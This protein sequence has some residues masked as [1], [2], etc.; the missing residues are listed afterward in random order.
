MQSEKLASMGQLAAGVAHE[1]NNPLGIVL[2]YAHLLLEENGGNGQLRDD[3][4]TI[5]EQAD[6][7]KRI[8]SGLLNFARQNK[9]ICQPTNVIELVQDTIK[10]VN[11][12]DEITVTTILELDEP[13]AEIDREQIAQ[14]LVNLFTN[15]QSAMPSGG[16]LTVAVRGD[17][18]NVHLSV[19]DTGVGIPE[20]NLSKIF[21][22]FFTT[23][24]IGKGTGLGL[25]V[26]YGIVKMHRGSV[27]VQSNTDPEKG[28]CGTVF[29]VTLPRFEMKPVE[30]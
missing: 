11:L 13:V 18:A 24:Q 14:L 2:M 27:K 19:R 21:D 6:R 30:V 29:S 5:V 12:P 3:L 4:E 1:V 10:T 28:P 7:C 23:K 20:E 17:D 25:A 15:A 16:E 26:L 22:P 9:T 8:V